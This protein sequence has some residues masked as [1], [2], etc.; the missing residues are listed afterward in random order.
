MLQGVTT[1]CRRVIRVKCRPL[2]TYCRKPVD[3]RDGKIISLAS[4]RCIIPPVTVYISHIWICVRLKK[5]FKL[6]RNIFDNYIMVRSLSEGKDL[7]LSH[8]EEIGNK[9]GSKG[10]QLLLGVNNGA[11]AEGVTLH[12]LKESKKQNKK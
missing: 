3:S 9:R 12:R 5:N 8:S 10:Q 11:M 4:H 7:Y 6:Y 1:Y 2:H